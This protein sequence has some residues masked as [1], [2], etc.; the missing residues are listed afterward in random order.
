MDATHQEECLEAIITQIAC[1]QKIQVSWR[2][3]ENVK[4]SGSLQHK[5]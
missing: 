2:M 5:S 4:T 1:I 3:N